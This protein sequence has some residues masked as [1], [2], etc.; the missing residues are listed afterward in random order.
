MLS[1]D[2]CEVLV[3]SLKKL[4]VEKSSASGIP[5]QY[6]LRGEWDLKGIGYRSFKFFWKEGKNK[7]KIW[8][9]FRDGR[10]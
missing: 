6:S 5:A 8:S 4:Y 2:S 10:P 3:L 1:K 7:S 9:N